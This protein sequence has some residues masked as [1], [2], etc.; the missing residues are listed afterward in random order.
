MP[1]ARTLVLVA[2]LVLCS[3]KVD[4]RVAD[5]AEYREAWLEGMTAL[6]AASTEF[7]SGACNIGGDQNECH[8]ISAGAIEA[9][10]TFLGAL[11]EAS[12]PA[13]FTDADTAVRSALQGWSDGLEQRNRGF[14]L[15]SDDD[16]REGNEKIGAAVAAFG[17][18]YQHFPAAAQLQPAP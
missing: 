4:V 14:E 9:I 13:D 18:A 12:V 8:A 5:D 1:K 2:I 10:D 11:G 16:F 7:E 3:C 15:Q 6:A 17:E